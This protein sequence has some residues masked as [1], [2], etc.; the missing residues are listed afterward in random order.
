MPYSPDYFAGGL[1]YEDN[2]AEVGTF[3]GAIGRLWNNINGTT[4][5]NL[6]NQL[7]AEKARV[8]SSAEAQKNRD[9]ETMMS[10][11]AYQRAVADMKAA[12]L[13]PAAIGGNAASTPSG[14]VA[15]TAA[16]TS[17]ASSGSG[18]F[19][20]L[21]AGIA[22]VA[23]GKALMAKF[24]NSAQRAADNHELI[25]QKV[26]TLAAQEAQALSAEQ[27]HLAGAAASY[28]SRHYKTDDVDGVIRF[29]RHFYG[30]NI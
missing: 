10:N 20:G 7:E 3:G 28:D 8:F 5:Q 2:G 13:N 30:K 22:K 23:I 26:K 21:I 17:A 24:M 25:G 14:A 19:L 1:S 29:L 12:G 9:W 4:A 15:G 11:T 16:A 27:K 6:F 18:G